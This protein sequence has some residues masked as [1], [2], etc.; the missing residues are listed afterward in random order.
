MRDIL[1][2]EVDE[3]YYLPQE[4]VKRL[5]EDMENRKALLFEPDEDALEKWKANELHMDGQID[6]PG[7]CYQT[8]RV[9]STGGC[10]PALPTWSG[11]SMQPK[12]N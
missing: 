10:G 12:M 5:I 3:K 2:D 4:K 1:E 11:G 8:G 6:E 9:Y 7:E